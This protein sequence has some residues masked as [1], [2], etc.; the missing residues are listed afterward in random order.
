MFGIQ[1]ILM[2]TIGLSTENILYLAGIIFDWMGQ[3]W[4]K[5]SLHRNERSPPNISPEIGRLI[6]SYTEKTCPITNDKMSNKYFAWNQ[7]FPG[8]LFSRF[9]VCIPPWWHVSENVS[10]SSGFVICPSSTCTVIYEDLYLKEHIGKCNLFYYD[11]LFY[12]HLKYVKLDR[13]NIL[14]SM[15]KR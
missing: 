1:C 5:I 8:K 4:I 11:G 14:F 12:F 3:G 9:P 7:R 15:L 10:L 6:Y 13:A 2:N